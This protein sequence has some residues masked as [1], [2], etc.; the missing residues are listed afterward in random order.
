MVPT[1]TEPTSHHGAGT[2]VL[3]K[4]H[5]KECVSARTQLIDP[6]S[7]QQYGVGVLSELVTRLDRVARELE[8]AVTLARRDGVDGRPLR[9]RTLV[10]DVFV[11]Y[12]VWLVIR[13]NIRICVGI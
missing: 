7:C 6:A 4:A 2:A 13:E 5:P 3:I 8:R 1:A 12:K 11:A 10:A 9:D